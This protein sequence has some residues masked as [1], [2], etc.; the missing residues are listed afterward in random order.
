[1]KSPL[2]VFVALLLAAGTASPAESVREQRAWTDSY[3]VGSIAP[4]LE[5]S[6]IWGS[7]HVRRG[8]PGEITVSVLEE[9]SA[10]DRAR[11]DRSLE[12]LRLDVTADDSRVA[13]VVGDPQLRWHRIDRCRGCRLDLQF[14]VLVPADTVVDVGTVMD[15][16]VQ[17]D[18][19]DGL[20]SASNVNG[21][22]AAGEIGN[23]G[24]ISS[25]N[26]DVSVGFVRAPAADCRIET[27]NGDITLNV[28][29]DAG[30]DVAL[31][32]FNGAVSSE[33]PADPFALPATVEHDVENGRATYRVRQLAGLRV[34][35]G[36]PVYSIASMNGDLRI[37]KQP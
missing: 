22:V 6:N 20:V 8:P 31:D 35:P 17:V 32:L 25:V 37:T 15:G 27:I 4:R 30:L 34:G 18:G 12:D 1:M 33:L 24:S 21:P 9:R 23:C 13:L 7:V 28:P 10:P 19:I 2:P 29:A 14:D 5:I 11:F 3:R 36:G 16:R 26:G